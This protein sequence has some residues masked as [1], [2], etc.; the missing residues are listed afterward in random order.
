MQPTPLRLFA[1]WAALLATASTVYS[2]PA[3]YG[4][5]AARVREAAVVAAHLA[6]T[7]FPFM[8]TPFKE[9]R[10][11]KIRGGF[12]AARASA[13]ASPVIPMPRETPSYRRTFRV[14]AAHPELTD[15]YDGLILKHARL[16]GLDARLVKSIVAAE[17]EFS[18]SALSPRGA[19]GL[20]QVVPATASE[21]GVHPRRLGDPESGIQAGTA[22]LDLLYRA[23]WRKYKLKG[24]AYERAPMWL[25][26]RIIAAYNAGPTSLTNKRWRRQTRDYV[27]KVLLYYESPVTLLRR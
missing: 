8:P 23:A 9:S 16:R 5:A 26:Q 14:L 6:R 27:R 1:V 7:A 10:R 12:P 17:S 2:Q 3:F 19:R 13:P 24:V 21:M 18:P 11:R 4:P 15:R 22:Y 25:R 20:M